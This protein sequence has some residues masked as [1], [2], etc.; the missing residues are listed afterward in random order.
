MSLFLTSQNDEVVK[1]S[2]SS[3]CHYSIRSF[4]GRLRD[5][6]LF[7]GVISLLVTTTSIFISCQHIQSLHFD[8]TTRD[9]PRSHEIQNSINHSILEKDEM[10]EDSREI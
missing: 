2:S 3:A 7:V 10:L 5:A 9:A 8:S 6:R 4:G 1:A